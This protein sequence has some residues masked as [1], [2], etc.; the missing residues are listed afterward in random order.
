MVGIYTDG[1]CLY[2]SFIKRSEK[3]RECK[4]ECCYFSQ[5]PVNNT[6][7]FGRCKDWLYVDC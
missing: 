5:M 4:K 3:K 2:Y 6:F 1:N 7:A